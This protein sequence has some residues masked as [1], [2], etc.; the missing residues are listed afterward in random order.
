[1]LRLHHIFACASLGAPEAKALSD[2]GLVEGSPNTHPGQ[3]TAN[4]RFFFKRGF[5]ELLWVHDEREAQADLAAPTK[6]WERWSERSRAANPFGICFSSVQGTESCLPF[7]TWVYQPAYLPRDRCLRFADPMPITE[8]EIFTLSWPQGQ[9]SPAAEPTDHPL[10]LFELQSL[11]IGLPDPAQ[12][13]ATLGCIRDAG[14]VEIHRSSTPQLLIRFA[15]LAKVL[16]EIPSLGLTIIG[17]PDPARPSPPV[18][19]NEQPA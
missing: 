3:G 1:M 19:H 11:S 9:A 15:A 7:A 18:D 5:L 2:A 12:V 10:G 16:L 14:L 4:R 8:P 13:S 6:L 17:N